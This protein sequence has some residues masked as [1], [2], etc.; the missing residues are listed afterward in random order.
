M[1]HADRSA[2][3]APMSVFFSNSIARVIRLEAALL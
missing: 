2:D 1:I 3:H